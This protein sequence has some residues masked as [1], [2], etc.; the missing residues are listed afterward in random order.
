MDGLPAKTHLKAPPTFHSF[1][2][3]PL[4]NHNHNHLIFKSKAST[5]PRDHKKKKKQFK[6]PPIR[7]KPFKES[8]AFP[9][10]LPLH[11]KNPNAIFKD[12]QRLAKQDK[13]KEALSIMDYLDQ[14]GI[15]T[16]PTTFSSL[17]AACVRS[18][19]LVEA[20]QIHAH[21][22]VNGLE[23]N[24]FLCTKLVH[25]YTSCGSIEDAK[26][27]FDEM[28][29]RSVYPWNALLRGNVVSGRRQY[30][31]ILNT[32][33]RMREL[34]IEL[35][36]YTF[37]CLIKSFASASAIG[38]GLKAHALLVKNGLI[39]S[40]ILRTTLI[41]MYFKCGKIKLAH[42]VFE[43]INERDIVVWGA[44]IAGFA[45]NRLQR[46]PIEYVRWMMREGIEPNSVILTTI[47]PV[48]GE[49]GARELGREVHAYVVKTKSYSKQLFVQSSLIDMYCKCGDMGSGRKVFYSSM[50]R[51]AISW[52]ALMS[53]YVSNGR[54]EQALRSIVWM[55]QEGF[56]PDVVTVA[57]ILPVCAQLRALRQGKEIH[58]FVVKNDFLPNVSVVTSLMIMY[59]KCGVLEYSSR[60]FERMENK[61]V[62]A[63][64]AMIDSHAESGSPEDALTVFRS[65]QLSK[66]R[67][68]SV[69]M[70][71]MLN[72]CGKLK[73]LKLGKEIHGQVLKK[74]FVSIPFVSAEIVKIYGV[75]G[76]N[77]KAKLVFD[78]IPVKGS[79]TWT[80]IIEAY[81]YNDRYQD[82]IDLFK[83]M[84]SDGFSPNHHTFKVVLSICERAGFAN[85]ACQIFNL[86][87]QRYNIKPSV[88]HYSSIIDLLNR[89]DRVEEAQRY[90]QLRSSFTT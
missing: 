51:S 4:H 1:L 86:M 39:N 83:E 10:S 28:P 87:T 3:N 85:E 61:N 5:L 19:S 80:S 24:E 74:D 78:T 30:R 22:L 84:R 90:N 53:G 88:E 15:P 46:E 66:H 72:V 41:D 17:I 59:S 29:S 42:R 49:V 45:H 77:D 71:R 38:Q 63:W 75:C 2:S 13:L 25:M 35:N 52:T 11:T 43:E 48:L 47:L 81:G 16:N 68:D 9:M 21:I 50:E 57:T 20:R 76:A 8:D 69:A 23:N 32:F 40:S 18:K 44:M 56:K 58:G 7:P 82:A 67:P 64:T 70:A 31:E 89:V 54:L 79:M 14:K 55:Q 27:V 36:V 37:S 34:G 65:M 73:V 12:I 6:F 60:L 26:R 33:W 62:I